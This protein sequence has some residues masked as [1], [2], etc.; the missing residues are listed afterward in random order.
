MSNMSDGSAVVVG[1][2]LV[3]LFASI[4]LSER[5]RKVTLVERAEGLGGLCRSSTDQNGA[6]YDLGTHIPNL[7]L[8]ER[9]DR[10]LFGTP[11]E[12]ERNWTTFE[13]ICPAAYS[14]GKWNPETSLMDARHLPQELYSR[15]TEEFLSRKNGSEGENLATFIEESFGPTFR[16]ALFAPLVRKLYGVEA[17]ELTA[18]SSVNYFG[19][20]RLV[21]FDRERTISLSKDEAYEARLGHATHED[22]NA[23]KDDLFRNFYL[24]PKGNH[25]IGFWMH[26]LASLARDRGVSILLGESVAQVEG[27]DGVVTSVQLQRAGGKMSCDLLAWTAPLEF[28]LKAAGVDPGPSKTTLRTTAIY[29]LSFDRPLLNLQA[30]YIWNWDAN[31]K[32]FRVTLYPNIDPAAANH[33]HLSAE[34]LVSPEE[35]D[36]V[37][38]EQ[39]HQELVDMGLVHR[40]ARVVTQ[41]RVVLHNTFPVPTEAHQA[42][43]RSHHEQ[44]GAMFRNLRLLGRHAGK[45]WFLSDCLLDTQRTIEAL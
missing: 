19:L 3:G 10:I 44:L 39:M 11:T 2:G 18:A 25:G 26:R 31:F 16:D 21:M 35:A 43:V 20:T 32:I 36:Q 29:Q 12:R 28:A 7:T 22:Y 37:S 42:E 4:L 24:Y 5:Y 45:V 23:S 34:I 6:V 8:N 41:Q 14:A 27:Q 15:G 1:G 40:D 33:H 17:S 9:A 13:Y 30:A 38:C